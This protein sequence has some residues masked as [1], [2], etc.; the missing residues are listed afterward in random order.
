MD[1]SKEARPESP[2]EGT[3][4]I[5]SESPSLKSGDEHSSGIWPS[6]ATSPSTI[7]LSQYSM[8]GAGSL[9]EWQKALEVII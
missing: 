4:S 3:E 7:L 6:T 2:N 8:L 1:K 5:I 9:A